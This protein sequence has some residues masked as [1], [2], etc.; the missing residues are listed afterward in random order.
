M[1]FYHTHKIISAFMWWS[2]MTY[3]SQCSWNIFLLRG[4]SC[5]AAKRVISI[6]WVINAA[7]GRAVSFL[8]CNM[9][10]EGSTIPH[11]C[12]HLLLRNYVQKDRYVFPWNYMMPMIASLWYISNCNFIVL[13]LLLYLLANSKS[14]FHF[15]ISIVLVLMWEFMRHL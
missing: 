12:C 1:Q 10:S 3:I 6:V 2:I 15:L 13:L 7:R 8:L 5:R 14:I 9:L 4:N 11:S